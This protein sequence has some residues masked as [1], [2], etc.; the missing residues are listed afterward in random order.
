MGGK[1]RV[2]EFLED[3]MGVEEAKER[4]KELEKR[5]EKILNYKC[6]SGH[7]LPQSYDL[8]NGKPG[9]W[10]FQPYH[11]DITVCYSPGGLPLTKSQ[12]EF[13]A[14]YRT[15]PMVVSTVG[16]IGGGEDGSRRKALWCVLLN[17]KHNAELD[18]SLEEL[19]QNFAKPLD[20]RQLQLDITHVTKTTAKPEYDKKYF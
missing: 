3:W 6:D 7:T 10:I 16:M 13:R 4:A 11:D 18:V 19:N 5:I 2:V 15:F 12:C 20:E 9:G 17:M 1:W 14:K 8:E